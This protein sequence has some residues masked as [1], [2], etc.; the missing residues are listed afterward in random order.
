MCV[1]LCVCA[2]VCVYA[3]KLNS[4]CFL[5]VWGLFIVFFFLSDLSDGGGAN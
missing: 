4:N 3:Q 1:C 2:Y 5:W